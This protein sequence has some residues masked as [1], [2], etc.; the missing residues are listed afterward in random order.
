MRAL[1]A[2][3][4]S[5]NHIELREVEHLQQAGNEVLIRVHAISLNR[6]EVNRLTFAEEG[7]RLG[8]DIAGTIERPAPNGEGPPEGE[9]VVAFVLGGGWA[10]WVAVPYLQVAPIPYDLS[11][12]A[13]STIPVAG[14]TA[15]RT[16]RHGG[17]LLGK[18]VLVTGASGGVGHYAV[19]LA[20]QGGGD[21]V[22]VSHRPESRDAL[23][24]L[25]AG[26]VVRDIGDADNEFDLILESVG[27]ESLATALRLIG[28]G[29]TVVTFGNSSRTPMTIDISQFYGKHDASLVGFSLLSPLQHP[30]FRPDLRF[31]AEEL[32]N[33]NLD[34]QIGL[35][36]SWQEAGDAMQAL[37]ARKVEGKAVLRVE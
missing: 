30:D 10:E 35:E 36:T 13:A 25:G 8:W 31:L 32:A 27:G 18:R 22:A 26:K 23:L 28:P 21:V 24:E 11:F 14:L 19:Q 6:G 17:L 1:V 37:L 15:L 34:P 3:P 5:K 20:A 12:A 33:G 2:S 29:G 4:Q 16:L 9:R 7:A